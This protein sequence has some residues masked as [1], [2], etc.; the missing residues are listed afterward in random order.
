MFNHFYVG[1]V[2]LLKRACILT[3]VWTLSFHNSI[4]FAKSFQS[5]QCFFH[6]RLCFFFV[7][8]VFFLCLFSFGFVQNQNVMAP[9]WG[10][11]FWWKMGWAHL[12]RLL[13]CHR[14]SSIN[15]T[16]RFWFP[17]FQENPSFL[18]RVFRQRH[19]DWLDG[20]PEELGELG[21]AGWLEVKPRERLFDE[22]DDKLPNHLGIFSE[23]NIRIPKN[24]NQGRIL[25]KIFGILMKVPSPVKLVESNGRERWMAPSPWHGTSGVINPIGRVKNWYPCIFGHL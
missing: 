24:N 18:A 4:G 25:W 14:I 11:F 15:S 6:T 9:I 20:R 2:F 8:V 22:G 5:F 19:N 21:S 23:A 1:E 10:S 12:Q 16:L 3:T 13:R 7:E 17:I